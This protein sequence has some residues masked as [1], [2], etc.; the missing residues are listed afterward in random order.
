MPEAAEEPDLPHLKKEGSQTPEHLKQ[1][2]VQTPK[3]EIP[4]AWVLPPQTPPDEESEL[5]Y[6]TLECHR[7]WRCRPLLFYH[8]FRGGVHRLSFRAVHTGA[9]TVASRWP[10]AV[11][12]AGVVFFN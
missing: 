4:D 9:V 1:E 6:L 8:L 5:T 11:T 3:E 10:M 2:A 7:T 12:T